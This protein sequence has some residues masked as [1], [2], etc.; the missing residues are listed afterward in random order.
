MSLSVIESSR[1]S[2][3][4]IWCPILRWLQDMIAASYDAASS[5]AINNNNALQHLQAFCSEAS[6]L[7]RAFLLAVVCREAVLI[8]SKQWEAKTYGKVSSKACVLP[9][10]RILRKLRL[11]L[12]V[13]LRLKEEE[14]NPFPITVAHVEA[15][16]IFSLFQWVARD[17]LTLSHKQNE[18]DNVEIACRRSRLKL[19]PS[20]AECDAILEEDERRST[21]HGGCICK[22]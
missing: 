21:R 18:V 3:Y 7:P 1:A 4:D 6:D 8:T 17:Q 10:D 14:R 13:S 20:L 16:N 5:N 12:V 15:G 9:W 22:N 11:C 2:L 19:C